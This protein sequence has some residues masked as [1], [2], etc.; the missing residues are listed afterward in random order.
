MSTLITTTSSNLTTLASTANTGDTYFE[1]DNN[2]IVTWNGTAWTYYDNDGSIFILPSVNN[3]L[4]AQ[5]DGTDDVI[6]CGSNTGLDFGSGPFTINCWV[7]QLDTGINVLLERVGAFQISINSGT[8][9]YYGYNSDGNNGFLSLDT[10]LGTSDWYMLTVTHEGGSSSTADVKGYVNGSL[11]TTYTG[12]N[13]TSTSS[14]NWLMGKVHNSTAYSLNGYLDEVGVWTRVLSASD[15]SSIYNSGVPNDISST[16]DLLAWW[17][18]GD[19]SGD[20]NSSSGTPADGDTIGTV[21]NLANPGTHDGTGSG[22]A[23]YAGGTGE[24]P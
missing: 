12:N 1:T 2:R 20:T 23:V 19:G 9:Y 10:G 5:F 14:G 13:Y 3:T 18:M 16:S 8:F 24:L 4:S 15:I 7:K 17:R 11:I 22:G 6:N 21:K